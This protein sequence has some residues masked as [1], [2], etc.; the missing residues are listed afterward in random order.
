MIGIDFAAKRDYSGFCVMSRNNDEDN[1]IIHELLRDRFIGDVPR[2]LLA[3]KAL[4]HRFP[5]A[6]IV[7]DQF[8]F[9]SIEALLA[10]KRIS[11][12][13]ITW[14][15]QNRSTIMDYFSAL[16]STGQIVMPHSDDLLQEA[17]GLVLRH[18]R[19]GVKRVQHKTTGHDDLIMS[20]ALCLEFFRAN[21]SQPSIE[22]WDLSPEVR[23]PLEKGWT[24]ILC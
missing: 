15:G 16:V 23:A 14:T 1:Y 18:T 8:N 13:E 11:V 19:T 6:T 20:V 9:S 24:A 2:F 21:E 10:Q 5:Q 7:M 17:A 22:I 4:H 3:V 12:E